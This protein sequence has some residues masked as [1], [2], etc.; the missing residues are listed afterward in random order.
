MAK[1]FL[2]G[3]GI[4]YLVLSAWCALKPQT[5]ARSVGFELTPGSGQSEYLVVYGG[6]QF[7]LG[8]LFLRVWSR[9]EDSLRI[10]EY[11]LIVHASLVGF[12]TLGFMMFQGFQTTT[13]ALAVTEWLVLIVS[14]GLYWGGRKQAAP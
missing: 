8:C 14:A 3:V 5:T 11:C 9:R 12:R 2:T 7:A 13:Y 4:L 1:P 10:L 6:L